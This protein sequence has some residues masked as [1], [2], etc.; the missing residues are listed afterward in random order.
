MSIASTS[1]TLATSY[2]RFVWG[3]FVATAPALAGMIAAPG[4]SLQLLGMSSTRETRALFVLLALMM[5]GIQVRTLVQAVREPIIDERIRLRC[6]TGAL[7][8]AAAAA[9]VAR[10][11][12]L[13]TLGPMGWGV[14]ASF[15]YMACGFAWFAI[16][17]ARQT[18]LP[19][20]N[21]A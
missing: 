2:R 14:A 6:S 9:V 1:A 21:N 11:A 20:P 13:G 8:D 4:W 16:R 10:E 3:G 18:A 7:L 5:A 19:A 12:A 15:L 17:S